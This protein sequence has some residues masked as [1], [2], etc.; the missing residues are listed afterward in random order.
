MCYFMK[1]PLIKK[2][3]VTFCDSDCDSFLDQLSTIDRHLATSI[4][5]I[6]IALEVHL[7]KQTVLCL[8]NV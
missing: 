8:I 1:S 7:A 4:Q 5:Q 3:S 6:Q 2:R